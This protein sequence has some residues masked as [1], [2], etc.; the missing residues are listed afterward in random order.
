MRYR[1]E[2]GNRR[3]RLVG[4][5]ALLS[6]SAL[7]A[8][9]VPAVKTVSGDGDYRGSAT[10]VQAM[11][12][13]CP[14]PARLLNARISV[15]SGVMFFPWDTQ[16]IQTSVLSNGTVSGSLPGVQLAGTH[17]GTTIEGDV[18]DGQCWLHF[19]L[20]KVGA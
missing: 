5:L 14:R 9:G 16:F 15:R 4:R 8:C 1:S 12:R 11:R 2:R 6:L 18:K 7:T 13:D 19:T 10:R 17:D 20:R 3:L